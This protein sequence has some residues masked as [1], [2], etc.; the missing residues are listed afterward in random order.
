MIKN[1][2][3]KNAVIYCL[4]VATLHG[5]GIGAGSGEDSSGQRHQLHSI[6]DKPSYRF[7][8]KKYPVNT[9]AAQ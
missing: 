6:Y 3:P 4:V 2:R 9:V 7:A 5:D 8:G 1:L